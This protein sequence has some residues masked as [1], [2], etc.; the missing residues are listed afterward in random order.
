MKKHK[1]NLKSITEGEEYCG[2]LITCYQGR[3]KF[4]VRDCYNKINEFLEDNKYNIIEILEDNTD[5]ILQKI[6]G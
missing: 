1:S 6:E 4:V 2:F 3:E 5:N